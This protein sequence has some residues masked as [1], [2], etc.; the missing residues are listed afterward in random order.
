MRATVA[1]AGLT[2]T[3]VFVLTQPLHFHGS[4]VLSLATFLCWSMSMSKQQSAD[5]GKEGYK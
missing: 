2:M 4:W 5:L 1:L 3:A